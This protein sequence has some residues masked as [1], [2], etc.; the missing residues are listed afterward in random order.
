MSKVLT[1]LSQETGLSEGLI[2]KIISTA[3]R[4]YKVYTIPKRRGGDRTIAQPAREVKLLQR[5][6]LSGPLK[7]IKIHSAAMAYRPGISIVENAKRHA[8]LSAIL[9]MDFSNFFPSITSFDWRQYCRETGL[10]SDEM[11]VELTSSLLFRQIGR[12]S[13][14]RLAIGAPSSPLVSNA[15]MFEFDNKVQELVAK[16]KVTYTRYAD[17]LTF[18]APRTGYLNNVVKNVSKTLA[19]ISYPKIRINSEKT[20]VATTKYRRNVTGLILANDGRVTVGRYRKRLLSAMVNRAKANML[21][22]AQKQYLAGYLAFVS[23]VEPNFIA[24]LS[25]RYG[26]YVIKDIQQTVVRGVR[27]PLD[28]KDMLALD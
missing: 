8:G 22:Q 3:P 12:S 10:F 16:D 11:D 15:L 18:S 7:N 19:D 23:S 21:T 2:N 6:L 5:A 13:R 24:A 28:V 14:L 25:N 4:R 9:K 1:Y 27:V 17:D 20:L 26:S